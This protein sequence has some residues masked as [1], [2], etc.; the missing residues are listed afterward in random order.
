[1]SV[2]ELAKKMADR[3]GHGMTEKC[4]IHAQV[5]IEE[6]ERSQNELVASF[7]CDDDVFV[8]YNRTNRKYSGK[9]HR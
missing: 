3:I 2:E 4:L 9:N 8:I 5:A 6:F 7:I 1:M